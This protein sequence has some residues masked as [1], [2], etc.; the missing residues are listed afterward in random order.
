MIVLE[1]I[2]Q[3]DCCRVE[4]SGWDE[5]EIFFVEKSLLAWDE[6]AGNY[7]SL[8][9]MLADGAIIFIRM[10]QPSA[11]RRS[12]PVA[13]EVEFAGCS[14]DGNHQFRLSPAKPRY[15]RDRHDVN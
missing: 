6:F 5:N 15:A 10:L 13:Y 8:D 3:T 1:T 14:P 4:A 9:H 2:P 11:L 7:I 12:S